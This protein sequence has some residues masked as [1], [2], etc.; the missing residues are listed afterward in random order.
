MPEPP[1][2]ALQLNMVV[3]LR[4]NYTWLIIYKKNLTALKNTL[5]LEEIMT[6]YFHFIAKEKN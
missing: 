4:V 3:P 2:H 5:N 6:K 1:P